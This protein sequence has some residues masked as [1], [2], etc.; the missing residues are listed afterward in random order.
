MRYI[1]K[2]HDYRI[3]QNRFFDL[4]SGKL[5]SPIETQNYTIIQVAESYYTHDFLIDN[6]QQFCDLEL[7]FSHMNG[8]MCSINGVFKTV[9]KNELHLTF[10]GEMHT[11]K[12]RRS[13][14]FQTLAINFKDGPC[15]PLLHAIKEKAKEQ[16]TFRIPEIFGCLT[17]V[18]SEFMRSDAPFSENH[19]DCLI[20]SVLVKFTRCGMAESL[21]E[22]S[23][24]DVKISTMKNYIDTRFLQI[25]CL[26][27]MS[28]VF[29]YTYSH[30]SKVFKKTYGVT[31]SKYLLE[32]KAGYACNLL[33]EGAKL[34]EIADILGYSTTFNFSRAFKNQ[35]GLSPNA[36]RK[37][38]KTI[39]GLSH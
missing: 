29:G 16:R 33:K 37:Q 22:I 23:S 18:I 32:K 4:E 11:L 24:Y 5:L 9:D 7:T 10:S 19:L 34:E 17:E 36:Y 28:Y 13:A 25:C 39:K 12:S 2:N 8:L 14:R 20:T 15:L 31:P 26:E 35:T 27:E 1:I 21:D 6:H 3:F 38:Q 30:I